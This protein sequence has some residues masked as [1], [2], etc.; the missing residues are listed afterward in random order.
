MGNSCAGDVFSM[1]VLAHVLLTDLHPF[2]GELAQN[3]DGWGGD[4]TDFSP[5]EHIN[6]GD[7][8]WIFDESDP[9]NAIEPL[10]PPALVLGDS[11]SRTLGQIFG[12]G[13]LKPHRRPTMLR[14]AH[15]LCAS[16][17]D[18]V[19]CSN[20]ACGMSWFSNCG[21]MGDGGALVCPY[22]Q[23]LIHRYLD[24][25]SYIFTSEGD[26]KK[27][28]RM[29]HEM[30]DEEDLEIPQCVVLPYSP[31]RYAQTML[32]IRISETELKLRVTPEDNGVWSR[33][34]GN[35][36]ATVLGIQNSYAIEELNNGIKLLRTGNHTPTV[37]LE[38]NWKLK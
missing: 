37:L 26:K 20:P 24:V 12:E 27:F 29:V 30:D 2:E 33:L 4:P 35:N 5:E 6:R 15:C 7:Y 38:I 18:T 25:T 23:A 36:E 16:W 32:K 19:K 3:C 34:Q 13:R 8:P 22:C 1:G 11:L 21:D 14:L 9:S 31:Q 28:F 17:L 10:L